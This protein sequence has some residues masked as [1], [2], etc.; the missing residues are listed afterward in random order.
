MID[1]QVKGMAELEQKLS[2]LPVR[3]ERNVV[4]GAVRAGSNV[5]LK[6]ARG[7][8]PKRTGRLIKSLKVS[9]RN[10]AGRPTGFVKV[11]GKAAPYAGPTEAGAKP[12]LILPKRRKYLKVGNLFVRQVRHPGLPARAFLMGVFDTQSRSALDA[13]ESYV[14]QR[15]PRELDKINQQGAT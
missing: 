9:T 15:L 4:R 8:F 3:I 5:F 13:F 14:A 7:A 6:A 12:H 10:T 1:I 2:D 11:G